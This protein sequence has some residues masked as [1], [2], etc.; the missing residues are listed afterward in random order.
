MFLLL[1]TV[2]AASSS[3]SAPLPVKWYAPF[4]AGGG[5][6]S[7]AIS[8]ALE[9]ESPDF[10]IVQFAEPA[11]HG[12]AR[13]VPR[14]AMD[15][16]DKQMMRARSFNGPSIQICHSTPDAWVPSMFPG[17]DAVAPCPH[18]SDA[19]YAIGR[20]MYETDRIPVSW[21]ERCNKMDEIWVPTAFHVEAFVRSGVD[22]S[23]L[24]TMPEAVDTA[25]FDPSKVSA[26]PL[27]G[28]KEGA[29][30]FLSVFKWERRKGWEL[31]LRAFFE[32]F[33]DSDPV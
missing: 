17:W 18:P 16:L 33:T 7:E 29:F 8:Y 14:A 23:K 28:V 22:R 30:V 31:L 3:D 12:F 6:S 2:R 21:V 15:I 11:D 26:M 20:T 13:G 19:A 24:V 9:L 32:E 10:A 5:Y 25:F 1:A 4:L 27:D